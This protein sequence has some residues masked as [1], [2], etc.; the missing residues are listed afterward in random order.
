[1]C[2]QPRHNTRPYTRLPPSFL[3]MDAWTT[4]Q[5]NVALISKLRGPLMCFANIFD[6]VSTV[7]CT[8]RHWETSGLLVQK[9]N[10]CTVKQG[11]LSLSVVWFYIK[12]THF[13]SIILSIYCI[14]YLLTTA[15]IF[16]IKPEKLVQ[17]GD[18]HYR[19]GLSQDLETGCPEL[20]I[21]TFLGVQFFKGDHNIHRLNP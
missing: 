3:A 8:T 7:V 16:E 2:G 12:Q 13:K 20:A 15:L 14:A 18:N 11:L 19:Q 9:L 5:L 10:A 6:M 21:L 17:P 1:M 4:F